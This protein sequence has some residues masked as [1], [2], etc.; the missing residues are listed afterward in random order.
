VIHSFNANG[1]QDREN[2]ILCERLKASDRRAF[3]ALFQEMNEAL[4]RY[5]WRITKEEAAAQDVVQ[6]AFLKLWQARAGLDQNRS[7][8][9]LLYTM[10]RNQAL[11]HNRALSQE[12]VS[13][14]TMIDVGIEGEVL[15]DTEMDAAA[16]E[17]NLRRWVSGMPERRRE[18]FE[19]SRFEGLNHEEIAEIMGLSPS[20]VN[21]HIVM[22]LQTLREKLHTFAPEWN[23]EYASI[24]TTK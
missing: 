19:L 23:Q 1:Q 22:A 14:D 17:E 18:A 12:N 8:R 20:T 16:L 2:A 21:R 3:S 15:Q 10:T 5:A 13:L 11:N 4:L 9:G 24:D 6:D 7:V